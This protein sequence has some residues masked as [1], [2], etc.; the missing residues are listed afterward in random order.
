MFITKVTKLIKILIFIY[1]F[2]CIIHVGCSGNLL[3]IISLE[4]A[5]ENYR[6]TIEQGQV[7]N[8]IF[9]Q[10]KISI[11]SSTTV[12]KILAICTSTL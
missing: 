12:E 8:R 7:D 9:C 6:I 10:M 11:E 3:F 4:F 5:L 1:I 2:T